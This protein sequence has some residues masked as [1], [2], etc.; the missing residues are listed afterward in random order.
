MSWGYVKWL[1][2]IPR[3]WT[4]RNC[5]LQPK[6]Y[7]HGRR[8]H[9][10]A[11]VSAAVSLR[12]SVS[13]SLGPNSP[14]ISTGTTGSPVDSSFTLTCNFPGCSKLMIP[15]SRW[16]QYHR[17]IVRNF[18]L[19]RS[20]HLLPNEPPLGNRAEHPVSQSIEQVPPLNG[21]E[22]LSEPGNSSEPKNWTETLV[23]DY[24][25]QAP[26]LINISDTIR[27][28]TLVPSTCFLSFLA[29]SGRVS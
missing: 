7:A 5:V 8:Y 9:D 23:R 21:M 3:D 14:T 12:S 28:E 26:P 29:V 18:D 24:P 11:K 10:T 20:P 25:L 22:S 17:D 15:P 27:M 6:K 1:I 4:C 2:L 19:S 13:S 16:C